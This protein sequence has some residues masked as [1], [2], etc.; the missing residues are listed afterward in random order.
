M[1]I[2]KQPIS[3]WTGTAFLFGVIGLLGVV[4]WVSP[5]EPIDLGFAQLRMPRI[6]DLV[7]AGPTVEISA[8]ERMETVEAEMVLT[9]ADSARMALADTLALYQDFFA[10][11]ETSIKFPKE[12]YT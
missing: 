2:S 1:K 12:D 10:S 5:N 8:D 4:A 6:A 9:A 3:L 11:S 7:S